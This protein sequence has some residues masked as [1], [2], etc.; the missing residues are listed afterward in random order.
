MVL[1]WEARAHSIVSRCPGSS[2][3]VAFTGVSSGTASPFPV[4]SLL[5]LQH[6]LKVLTSVD[7][8]LFF[9]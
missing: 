2:G 6:F 3:P 5:W 9:L 8:V 4:S 1:Q 7:H